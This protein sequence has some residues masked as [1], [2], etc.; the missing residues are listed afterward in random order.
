MAFVGLE[1]DDDRGDS[2]T[3]YTHLVLIA[4]FI[5]CE[6]ILLNGHSLQPS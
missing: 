5:I 3:D 6:L 4:S 2:Q 1:L